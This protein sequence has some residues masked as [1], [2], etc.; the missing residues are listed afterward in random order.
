MMWDGR[1]WK[2]EVL[3]TGS[4]TLTCKFEAQLQSFS[5][6]ITGVYALNCYIERRSV[7]EEIG[8]VRGLFHGPWAVCGDF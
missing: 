7:W 8:D 2:G 4:Y 5:C 1:I 6:N 3:E